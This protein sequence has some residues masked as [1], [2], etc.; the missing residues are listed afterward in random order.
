MINNI[1]TKLELLKRNGNFSMEQIRVIKY[2]MGIIGINE[3]LIINPEIPSEYM[4]MY[5]RLMIQ[6][7]D[8]T[9]YIKNNWKLIEIPV[10]DLEKA[11]IAENRGKQELNNNTTTENTPIQD[12]KDAI[13]TIEYPRINKPKQKIKGNNLNQF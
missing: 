3:N 2:A 5:I 11:I 1:D 7:I 12:I 8:V 13:I 4:S 6:G 9:K 10:Y